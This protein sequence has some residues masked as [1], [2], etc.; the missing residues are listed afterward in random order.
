MKQ[1]IYG[2]IFLAT[3]GIITF[4][5]SKEELIE[6]STVQKVAAEEPN[7]IEKAGPGI[8]IIRCVPHR[9]KFNCEL[10][11]GLCD[12]EW[13]PDVP[14]KLSIRTELD[15]QSRTMVLRSQKFVNNGENTLYVDQDLPIS[16]PGAEK[17]GYDEIIIKAG[18][19]QKN[20][21]SSVTV[22][23]ILIEK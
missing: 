9:N 10:K 1:L 15:V 2:T 16:K 6:N 7:V 18:E 14:R 17:H 4:S 12:C 3:I 19:Y 20:N 13:F 23:V 22:D 21:D 8:V 11:W 5:C